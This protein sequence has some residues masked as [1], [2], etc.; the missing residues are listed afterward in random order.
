[1]PVFSGGNWFDCEHKLFS[2]DNALGGEDHS[3]P[4]SASWLCDRLTT[5][6]TRPSSDTPLSL[7]ALVFGS[8]YPN[9]ENRQSQISTVRSRN[10]RTFPESHL[11]VG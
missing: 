6:L 5:E 1:M 11:D 3:A 2:V 9:F 8:R 7:S 4:S 10:A